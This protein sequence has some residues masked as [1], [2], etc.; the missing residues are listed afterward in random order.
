MSGFLNIIRNYIK[1]YK[2]FAFLN[3]GFN[4]LG[5]IFSLASMILIGPFLQVLFG[6]TEIVDHKVP[7]EWSKAAIENNFNYKVGQIIAENGAQ[8]A[9]LAISIILVLMFFL[10]T[11]NV[12]LANYFMAP[13]RNGV[14]KD[15]RNKIYKKIIDLPIGFF[16]EERK[17]DVMARV[18]QDVQEIEWS[19]MA[20]LEKFFRDPINIIIFLIGLFIIS[21]FLTLF[22]L[23]LLPLSALLIGT[24]GKNLRKTSSISQQQMGGLM[25]FLEESLSGLR[26]IKAFNAQNSMEEGFQ[27]RNEA[28][29][30][31]MNQITRR[32][33]LAS[34]LSEFLGSIV[35]VV[36]LAYGGNMVLS[37][38]EGLSAA[39]FI[40]YIAIF[41]QLLTPAKSFSTAFYHM[42]KGLASLDRVDEILMAKNSIKEIDKPHTIQAFT[43]KIEF[44]N[45]EF[46]YKEKSVLNNINL[47][48]KKGACIA[49]IGRSGSG[50]STM[51]DL[52]PRF[53]DVLSGEIT[54]DNHNIKDLSIHSLRNLIGY[55]H[56][57]SL[58]FNDTFIRNIAFG[59]KNPDIDRIRK[60]AKMAFAE[61]FILQKSD[62]YESFIGDR[63]SK[64][65]GGQR[66]RISLARALYL[67]PEI[68]ILDEA[69]S[70][71]DTESERLVQ[72]ALTEVQ[73]NRTSIIVAHR[74]STIQHADQI[75]VFK[76]GEIVERGTHEELMSNNGEYLKLYQEN[77]PEKSE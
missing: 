13:I 67:D 55:V 52:L 56:Q 9:L 59:D 41:S 44:R 22:V 53:Y 38:T 54:I 8:T 77:G 18:T 17:G 57:D 5:V 70:S 65:S 16:T 49:L 51:V 34:P 33:Y 36:L 73:K 3:I 64:L 40:A 47:E 62:G 66:Q 29:T 15:I 50:K 25:S 32:R 58:L 43:D 74:L 75:F 20:S 71:L 72:Q 28:Y 31:T 4:L 23:V 39:T 35:I 30:K 19:I 48:I 45:V 26:I 10:K 11:T 24:I 27:S 7:W 69:T 1:P 68:L 76:E 61:D 63:G 21:P 2:G 60:A 37:G 14:V 46:A 12:Y 6:T 42:Q